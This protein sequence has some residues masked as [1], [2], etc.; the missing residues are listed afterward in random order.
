MLV[1]MTEMLQEARRKKMAI[2]AI[3]TPGF[4]IVRAVVRAAEELDTPVILDHAS[5]HDVDLPVEL[6]G[7]F[8]VECAKKAKVPVCCNLDHGMTM[9]Q[10]LRAMKAG[11]TS[12]MYDCSTMPLEENIRRVKELCEFVQPLG[13][14]VEAEIGMMAGANPG[15]VDAKDKRAFYTQPDVAA[16]FA[17][18]TKCDALAVCIGT[19]H[20]FYKSEPDLDFDL[21]SGI[22]KAV[23][24]ETALVMHGSSGV[25]YEDLQRAITCGMSKINYYTYFSIAVAPKIR[26][27]I[28]QN[29]NRT[30][31]EAVCKKAYEVMVEEAKKVILCMRNGN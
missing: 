27:L 11:F 21:L 15:N 29:P 23:R 1:N 30:Y 3:N 20:G 14:S 7:P 6:I 25:S 24:S 22:R 8:M 2:A 12:F 28:D 26:E 5:V 13:Y 18:E 31:Y 9:Q 10:V 4:D 16:R 17:E 19:E